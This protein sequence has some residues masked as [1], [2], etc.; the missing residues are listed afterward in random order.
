MIARIHKS[1]NEKDKGFTLIEL[2]VVIII[3][4]ILAAIAIPVFMNQRKKAVDSA[5]KSDLRTVA[6]EM[7]TAYTDA[8]AYP[9]VTGASGTTTLTPATGTA[10]TVKISTGNTVTGTVS[11]ESYC[12]VGSADGGKATQAWVYK[13]GSG[14]LQAKGVVDCT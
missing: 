2:L 10:T 7:E 9:A 14:G 4:G 12:L 8:Q 6:N 1:M 11:G 5:I 13:S 3:I